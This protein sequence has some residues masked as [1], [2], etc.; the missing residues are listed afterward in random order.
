M[1]AM[2]TELLD[3]CVMLALLRFLSHLCHSDD[4]WISTWNK[5]PSL[6]VTY[7]G[8]I[9]CTFGPHARRRFPLW[10]VH[11]TDEKPTRIPIE[12]NG[13]ESSRTCPT[14][15]STSVE[16]PRRLSFTVPIPIMAQCCEFPT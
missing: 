15:C 11:P 5:S 2:L 14:L 6:S 8:Y 10:S 3:R 1:L 12:I 9:E 13:R 7:K 16:P 4:T